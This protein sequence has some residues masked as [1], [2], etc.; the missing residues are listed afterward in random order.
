MLAR[1]LISWP[2]ALALVAGSLQLRGVNGEMVRPL[3]PAGVANVLLFVAT[4]C[5]VSNT[6]A[7]EIQRVCAAAAAKDI[8]CTLVYEDPGVTADRVRHHLDEFRYKGLPAVIDADG[9][10]AARMR[11]T[12]TPEAIVVDRSGAVS[13]RGRIDNFYAA[14]GRPRQVVTSHDLQDALDTLAAGRP[15]TPHDAPAIGCYIVPANLRRQP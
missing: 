10:L 12:I 2:Y 7:P 9:S 4:D 11:A 5:P 6:Y 13:Y 1:A 15:V 8:H 14:L 3:E